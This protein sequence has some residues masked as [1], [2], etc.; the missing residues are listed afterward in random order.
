M[1][2]QSRKRL[3]AS[4][5]AMSRTLAGD[6]AIVAPYRPVA[7]HAENSKIKPRL[8]SA[9]TANVSAAPPGARSTPRLVD[10]MDTEQGPAD[11]LAE[12]VQVP[13]EQSVA[14]RGDEFNDR[15][16]DLEADR[17][18][19]V[20]IPSG[21]WWRRLFG[22][23][24]QAM[25]REATWLNEQRARSSMA[26]ARVANDMRRAGNQPYLPIIYEL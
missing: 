22:I 20:G 9:G 16:C 19:Y 24:M 12:L 7:R 10:V 13:L 6:G 25:A 15:V 23:I 14:N 1:V 2:S 21:A 18:R 26:S 11:A 8:D 3:Q 17:F 5:A 4:F